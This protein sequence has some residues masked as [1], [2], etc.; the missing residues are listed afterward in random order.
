METALKSL[1][2][3]EES[4]LDPGL[5]A[6]CEKARTEDEAT[7]KLSSIHLVVLGHVDA[8]K[9]T[10]MGRMLYETGVVG[11]KEVARAQK[12]AKA[13]GKGSFAWAWMLDERPEERARG[14]T[15]D[16]ATAR[17]IFAFFAYSSQNSLT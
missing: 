10:M 16:V 2:V 8:G 4:F 13:I 11:E 1:N 9:S 14:V 6:A 3:K 7:S 12:D 5:K 17:Y 15:V